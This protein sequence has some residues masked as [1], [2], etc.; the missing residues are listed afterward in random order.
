MSA[1][2][3]QLTDERRSFRAH[4]NPYQ[5]YQEK[6]R[7]DALSR[8]K[9]ARLHS[10]KRARTL[11]LEQEEEEDGG[12]ESQ[13]CVQDGSGSMEDSFAGDAAADA[14][15]EAT[16]QVVAASGV[17]EKGRSGSKSGGR[18]QQQRQRQ[19]RAG[20][21]GV[22]SYGLQYGNELMQPEWLTDVPTD[23]ASNW[24]VMPRPEG[25]RCL[26]VTSRGRTVSWLRNGAPLHRFPSALP[27]GSPATS[28]GC[29]AA[30]AGAAGPASG[31]YCIL[32]CIFHPPN[33]TYYI[34][35]LLCW[36]GYALYDCA[37]EFR[38]FWLASKLQEEGLTEQVSVQQPPPQPSPLHASEH[39]VQ[40]QQPGLSSTGEA[41][42]G[43]GGG[44]GP[45]GGDVDMTAGQAGSSVR[46]PGQARQEAPVSYRIVPLPVW[47]CTLEGLRAA[48]GSCDAAQSGST[49]AASDPWVSAAE[50]TG[51]APAAV[52]SCTTVAGV[53]HAADVD[54]LRDGL[55]LLHRQ[56]HYT[57]GPA[58][59]PLALLWKDLGCSRYLVDTDA[60]GAP[61]AHQLVSLTYR[62][63]RTVA[64]EDE[65]PVVLGRLPEAFVAA[66]GDKLRPGRLL[67][68]S[69][70]QGGITFHE[71]RPVGA[72][73]HYE[74]PANQ[75]RGRAD[76]FSKILFQR[77]ARTA[78]IT[79]AALAAAVAADAGVMAEAAAAAG[80]GSGAGA[81]GAASDTVMG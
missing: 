34:Q 35:D 38:A 64:T 45:E 63:D 17:Q 81:L 14:E 67:R 3:G 65:P 73:L 21:G 71:G 70:R 55:Y 80:A 2:P 1:E 69:I 29:G 60:Q 12:K 75:R 52:A 74:G 44:Q 58:P 19:Q 54:F 7:R 22:R 15:M 36:R 41:G 18:R 50:T 46:Q 28:G 59:T 11:A 78:P 40:Q 49:A 39:Q 20:T 68:F 37:A 53:P 56:G 16:S 66:M 6:R 61:L 25:M 32:D 57:P 48:Y 24:M 8:Q 76:T 42:G 31:D 26:L 62:A 51:P 23:L 30:A 9:A 10:A 5:G 13:S 33:N 79:A 27:G 47:P 77:M 72:D 4:G 43:G